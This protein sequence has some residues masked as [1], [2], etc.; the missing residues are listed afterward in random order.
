MT[1]APEPGQRIPYGIFA[2]LGLVAV[3][4]IAL[5]RGPLAD[6]LERIVGVL[7]NAV[8]QIAG[9]GTTLGGP[10]LFALAF[11]GGL[12]ASIS[13]CILGMLP[14]NLAYIGALGVNSRTQALL[15]ASSFVVGVVVINSTLGLF[16]SLFFALFVQYR[17][18]VNIGV[19]GLMV[20][21]GLWMIGWIRIRVPTVS[22]IPAAAG[23]FVVGMAFALV[24]SPCASP[25]LVAVL[26]G[27]AKSG[28]PVA[29]A[30]TMTVYSLGYTAVLFL[31]SLSAGLASASRRLL[32]YGDTI[33]RF[34]AAA[35]LVAGVFTIIYGVSQE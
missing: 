19:G 31:A 15:V 34:A 25:V 5:A 9:G 8:V 28:S 1:A 26:A 30:A 17:V 27:A 35:L 6:A 2:A 12:V 4:A 20:A 13:P 24:A 23:P 11:I 21:M 3:A 32:R 10:A 29:G 22:R 7:Q 18:I 14:V 33:S 16:S